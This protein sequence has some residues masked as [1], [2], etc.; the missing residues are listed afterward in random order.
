M[1]TLLLGV[2]MTCALVLGFEHQARACGG[3]FHGER[4]PAQ[5][6]VETSVV[7]DHRMVFALGPQQTVLWDQIRYTG[8]PEDFAWVL[9]VRPGT[10]VELSR[11]AWIA[12]LDAV[13]GTQIV[14]PQPR[15]SN[16]PFGGEGDYMDDSSGC[17]CGSS[18]EAAFS[19]QAGGYADGGASAADSG[20]PPVQ[21]VSQTVVGPYET[22]TIR[23]EQPDALQTWLH[24]HGYAV[25][26]E[27]LPIIES[28]AKEKMDFVALRLRPGQGVRAMQ[29]VRIISPG[30]DPTLPLRMVAAGVGSH[31]G[32]TLF[33]VSEGRYRPQNFPEA[34]IDDSKLLWDTSQSRS[35]YAELASALLALEGGR[36]WLTEY[37][38]PLATTITGGFGSTRTVADQYYG[39]CFGG[40]AVPTEV[41]AGS[42]AGGETADAGDL[43]AGDPDAGDLD[44]GGGTSDVDA[45]TPTDPSAPSM[46]CT[47]ADDLC[48]QFDDLEL[49]VQSLHRSDVFLTRLRADLPA[50]ALGVDLR[51]EANPTQSTVSNVHFASLPATTTGGAMIAP[52]RNTRLGTG[53]MVLGTAFLVG[54]MV[55]RRRTG[56]PS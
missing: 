53:L 7:S 45:A 3:C 55:R 16:L 21:V 35:N 33:V 17:G 40:V 10:R 27:I 56:S 42:D 36:P 54:R 12:A 32:L 1:K 22:A 39:Q 47:R 41:D 52:A 48:C 29:P 9:P 20:T 18:S 28:Y 13:S 31:V 25:P 46:I 51:L 34:V 11:D 19:D 37:A 14:K 43:D 6:V 15:P 49:A 23:S 4:T 26:A 30:A 38:A 44:A 50:S 5:P 8:D 24:D 2:S